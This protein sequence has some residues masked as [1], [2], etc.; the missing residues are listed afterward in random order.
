M[1]RSA[2]AVAGI[3]VVLAA[4]AVARLASAQV[5][6]E[7]AQK[8]LQ[9]KLA[10]RPA[11]TQ[12]VSEMDR[13]RE[14][15]NRLRVQVAD[16]QM[17]VQN[18]RNSLAQQGNRAPGGPTTRPSAAMNGGTGGG[19]AAASADA[20]LVGHWRGGDSAHGAGYV[21]EFNPD[22]SY[23][24][25]FL[26]YPQHEEG[27]YRMVNGDTVEMWTANVGGGPRNQYHLGIENNQLTLTPIVI[28]GA[29]VRRPTPM[30]L[31]RAE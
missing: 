24:R 15:N 30:V 10:T 25:T 20:R 5:S 23:R 18:L 19:G 26:S 6:I 21:L 14:E 29:A 11:S 4:M 27:S 9:Q 7:E 2:A 28:E 12:P 16:L 13:L 17:E 1:K 31:S 3:G 22:G 8:R